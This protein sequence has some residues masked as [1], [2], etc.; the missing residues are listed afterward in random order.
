[1]GSNDDRARRDNELPKRPLADLMLTP[2]ERGVLGRYRKDDGGAILGKIWNLPNTALGMVF[3]LSGY[4]IGKVLGRNPGVSI[5]DNAV[6]FT[7][8]PLGGVGAITLG[9]TVTWNGN[10]YDPNSRGLRWSDPQKS[11]EHEKQHTYQGEQLGPAYLP[12]NILGGL[13]ALR[14]GGD[15][16]GEGNWNEVGPQQ[17]PPRPW[18]EKQ[19]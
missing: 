10:P 6:Q 15:W 7:N 8:N 12:S 17:T 3:G 14:K 2:A 19:Q 18:R 9:N 11:I 13:N 5:R 16:H 1:M 4:G